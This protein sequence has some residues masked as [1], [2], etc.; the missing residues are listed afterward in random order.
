[1]SQF[2]SYGMWVTGEDDCSHFNCQRTETGRI[3]LNC[4]NGDTLDVTDLVQRFLAAIAT[5][6]FF[7][8]K[9]AQNLL[10]VECAQL[11][12]LRTCAWYCSHFSFWLALMCR[13]LDEGA[14]RCWLKSADHVH[15]DAARSLGRGAKSTSCQGL[16]GHR[17]QRGSAVAQ[18]RCPVWCFY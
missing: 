13:K 11:R 14:T 8:R 3:S 6:D 17:H 18:R 15:L 2:A 5:V 7:F 16:L 4:E 10:L 12:I 1:M 9:C